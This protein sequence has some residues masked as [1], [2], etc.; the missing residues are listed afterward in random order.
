[1]ELI[2]HH[3]PCNVDIARYCMVQQGQEGH[4]T[5]HQHVP[6]CIQTCELQLNPDSITPSYNKL[7]LNPSRAPVAHNH[8]TGP[9][10]HKIML[11]TAHVIMWYRYFCTGKLKEL[12]EAVPDSTP[13][14]HFV[15]GQALFMLQL[16]GLRKW[17]ENQS[18]SFPCS[19]AK[20]V[21]HAQRFAIK[22]QAITQ[23]VVCQPEL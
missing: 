11:I 8:L 6:P 9:P 4:L 18:Q 21:I 10:L 17:L 5:S 15:H 19:L 13:S 20:N 23:L 16:C 3:Q 1:M 7:G 12:A 14:V 2:S 22:K